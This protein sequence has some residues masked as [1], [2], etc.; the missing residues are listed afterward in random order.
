MKKILLLWAL[1]M[2]FVFSS[3]DDDKDEPKNPGEELIGEWIMLDE[4]GRMPDPLV[5]DEI[6]HME[7]FPNYDAKEWVT[8]FGVTT[9]TNQYS[10][11]FSEGKL[12]FVSYDGSDKSSYPMKIEKGVLTI[13]YNGYSE[14]YKK[15]K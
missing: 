2:P 7:F 8:H 4:D 12:Y 11:D 9:E 14:Q 1:I 10:W 15:K 5:C 3:C 13:Y 6:W